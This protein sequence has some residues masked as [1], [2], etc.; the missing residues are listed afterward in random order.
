M[1]AL[2]KYARDARSWRDFAKV[3]H[4][5]AQHLFASG[6]PFMYLVAA[7]L[8]HH[9]LELYLKAALINEG[10]TAFGRTENRG[11]YMGSFCLETGG[12]TCREAKRVQSRREDPRP[13]TV[14]DSCHDNYS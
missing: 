7:T 14:R 6:N 5:A 3:N 12:E 4:V 11:L 9:A 2:D 8:G 1:A 10:M 13:A